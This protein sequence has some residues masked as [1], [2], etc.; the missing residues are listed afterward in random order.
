MVYVSFNLYLTEAVTFLSYVCFS[1][2]GVP[3]AAACLVPQGGEAEAGVC[4]FF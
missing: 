2:A 4:L 3:A 1:C